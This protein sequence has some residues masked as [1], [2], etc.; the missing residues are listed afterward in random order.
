VLLG[1]WFRVALLVVSVV[2]GWGVAEDMVFPFVDLVFEFRDYIIFIFVYLPIEL[3]DDLD[4][5]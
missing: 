3:C 4:M 5:L 2:S 1:L